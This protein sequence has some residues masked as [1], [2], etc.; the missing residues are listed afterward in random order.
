MPSPARQGDGTS[1]VVTPL[2]V[3]DAVLANDPAT[4]IVRSEPV[5][6]TFRHTADRLVSISLA[7]GSRLDTTPGHKVH[8]VKRGW[9]LAS[10]LRPGDRLLR[11]GG[12]QVTVARVRSETDAAFQQVYDLT[13]DGP[14]TFYVRAEGSQAPDVLVHNCVNLSD[15]L[16]PSLRKYRDSGAMRSLTEHVLPDPAEAFR[17]A[18]RK[19]VPNT[20]WTSQEIA[21]Q[22]IDRVLEDHFTTVKS[23]QRVF[24]KAALERVQTEGCQSAGRRSGP[25]NISGRGAGRP[26]SP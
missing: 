12:T 7:D 23:G 19:G 11:P 15:E 24:D 13:V 14:N 4:G 9:V 20:V 25:G 18:R 17:T 21:Q 26:T 16:L 5:T 8:A 22:A 3:G 2:R 1:S 10:E 6:D